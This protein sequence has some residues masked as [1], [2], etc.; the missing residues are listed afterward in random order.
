MILTRYQADIQC[1]KRVKQKCTR[2]KS[3]YG[4]VKSEKIKTKETAKWEAD[5]LLGIIKGGNSIKQIKKHALDSHTSFYTF[6]LYLCI[7]YRGITAL[8]IL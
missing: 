1:R 6:L 3:C 8:Y 7:Y 4:D 2:Q 5:F